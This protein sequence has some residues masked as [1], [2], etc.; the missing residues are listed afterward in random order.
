MTITYADILAITIPEGM[1]VSDNYAAFL[2]LAFEN[3][4]DVWDK[5]TAQW[6]FHDQEDFVGDLISAYQTS[7]VDR[8][9]AR[10]R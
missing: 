4:I 3:A 6:L 7:C 9:A 2:D 8:E 10:Y 5:K 1:D